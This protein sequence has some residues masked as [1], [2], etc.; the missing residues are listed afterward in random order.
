MRSSTGA[1]SFDGVIPY[2]PYVEPQ[3]P[4]QHDQRDTFL[5][6][7]LYSKFDTIGGFARSAA[8][9]KALA[10]ALYGSKTTHDDSKS[11]RVRFFTN[12]LVIS[13]LTKSAEIYQ[14]VVSY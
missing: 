7:P 1:A 5:T 8:E 4:S 3:L 13:W 9:F 2:S 14:T 12:Y 6:K 10:R 11:V